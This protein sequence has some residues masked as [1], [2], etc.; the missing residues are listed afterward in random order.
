MNCG[1]MNHTEAQCY[2][3]SGSLHKAKQ[4]EKEK[5][6]E[7]KAHAVE[8]NKSTSETDSSLHD[9]GMMTLPPS[10]CSQPAGFMP[11]VMSQA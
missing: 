2:R 4:K 9:S 11:T 8:A 6:K 7:E 10:S 1:Y 5:K 3:P